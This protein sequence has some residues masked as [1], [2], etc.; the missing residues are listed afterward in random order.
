MKIK[1]TVI[2]STLLVIIAF[3][4]LPF[5]F[6]QMNL[7]KQIAQLSSEGYATTPETFFNKYF[8]HFDESKNANKA[9]TKSFKLLNFSEFDFI[10]ETVFPMCYRLSFL[11]KK[12]H[13]LR[14]KQLSKIINNNIKFSDQIANLQ[15]YDFIKYSYNWEDSYYS[16][17]PNTD[18]GLVELRVV[19]NM[20]EYSIFKNNPSKAKHWFKIMFHILTFLYQDYSQSGQ[21]RSYNATDITLNKLELFLNLLKVSEKDLI[22][23]SKILDKQED[24]LLNSWP[25]LWEWEFAF[26]MPMTNLAKVKKIRRYKSL[27]SHERGKQKKTKIELKILY[28][29]GILFNDFAEEIKIIKQLINL[30]LENYPVQM[31]KIKQIE[32][33]LLFDG[34]SCLSFASGKFLYPILMKTLAKVRCAK[35]VCA[36]KRFQLK[37]GKLPEKLSLLT[38]E[39]IE[40]I[41]KDPFDSKELKYCYGNLSV[42]I[43]YPTK[44]AP[45]KDYVFRKKIINKNGFC[46]YSPGKKMQGIFAAKKT[47]FSANSHNFIVLEKDPLN[48]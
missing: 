37:Y 36:I 33:K 31:A 43:F 1:I 10:Q 8:K 45:E 13:L 21:L 38:P 30:P 34:T 2:V 12:F 26:S 6:S 24:I 3:L 22:F 28:Y 48:K 11:D 9:F 15:N 29:T 46:V 32:K 35:V 25:R 27:S 41:P 40:K 20:L 4:H 18:I 23:F 5:Y 17:T 14:T 19:G 39:F 7:N 42:I 47:F 16:I 44:V